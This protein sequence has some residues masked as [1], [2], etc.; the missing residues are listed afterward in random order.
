MMMTFGGSPIAVAVPP[1]LENTT[2][3]ISTG[4]GSRFNTWQSLEIGTLKHNCYNCH[5]TNLM[6]TGVNS[7]MVVTLSC[8]H[9]LYSA[10]TINVTVGKAR[11][12]GYSPE[13]QRRQLKT[14]KGE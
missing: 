3:A 9:T 6:E 11:G 8:K 13:M 7:K 10:Y 1:M 2:S 5:V 12:Y 14:G 4:R